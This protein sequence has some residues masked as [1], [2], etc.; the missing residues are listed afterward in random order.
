M[1][2][3]LLSLC[4]IIM[5]CR[6]RFVQTKVPMSKGPESWGPKSKKKKKSYFLKR[7]LLKYGINHHFDAQI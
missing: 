3:Y 4:N 6:F 1:L 7:H 5:M 2:Q